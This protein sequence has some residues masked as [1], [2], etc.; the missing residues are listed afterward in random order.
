MDEKQLITLV[1]NIC[2]KMESFPIVPRSVQDSLSD[3]IAE[4]FRWKGPNDNPIATFN[5][6]EM[7]NIIRELG[8]PSCPRITFDHLLLMA[9]CAGVSFGTLGTQ[10]TDPLDDKT[11][12]KIVA[13][14][15]RA[16]QSE[17]GPPATL[18][19]V[20]N[21]L[22]TANC[23]TTCRGLLDRL[24]FKVSDAN[25][26]TV[27]FE[28]PVDCEGNIPK[29]KI[30]YVM[31]NDSH[32]LLAIKAKHFA[33]FGPD[34][35]SQLVLETFFLWTKS[36]PPVLF[37]ILSDARRFA[38]LRVDHTGVKFLTHDDDDH[39]LEQ[40]MRII[41]IHNESDVREVAGLMNAM[42]QTAIAARDH[43][44]GGGNRR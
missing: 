26:T 20:F 22:D 35:L 7:T 41:R 40:R 4:G 42:L 27:A 16:G 36:K 30:D 17:S 8:T 18:K 38:F 24:V 3:M 29:G 2:T 10:E 32:P 9:P 6:D 1:G 13:D 21:K 19:S 44:Q 43:N 33:T 25:G 28:V 31:L 23:E 15:C 14:I 37:G 34:A 5:S 39:Q 11:T 12:S